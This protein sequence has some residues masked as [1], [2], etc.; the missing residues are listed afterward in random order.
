MPTYRDFVMG[1][2]AT[3]KEKES[4]HERERESIPVTIRV[5]MQGTQ[6]GTGK[7]DL[8]S[9][10]F[11]IISQ[12]RMQRNGKRRGQHGENKLQNN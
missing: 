1:R 3:C 10:M 5:E 6:T 7:A 9:A 8:F 12:L 2:H 11:A 4:E